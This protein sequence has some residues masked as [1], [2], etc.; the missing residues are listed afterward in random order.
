MLSHFTPTGYANA[1]RKLRIAILFAC[2][3][4]SSF[5]YRCSPSA[6]RLSKLSIV[7]V[8]ALGKLF[9]FTF[10][11]LCLQQD[12]SLVM[13]LF[14][15]FMQCQRVFLLPAVLVVFVTMC[16]C[17][18]DF[19]SWFLAAQLRNSQ[20]VTPICRSPFDSL[21]VTRNKF[22]TFVFTSWHNW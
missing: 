4:V 15:Y 13:K 22:N 2:F 20:N 1:Q 8:F 12:L 18:C 16:C 14:F 11:I 7:A 9:F 10:V 19:A 6:C 5:I 3:L 17:F 21:V